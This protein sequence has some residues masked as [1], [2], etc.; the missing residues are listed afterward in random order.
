MKSRSIFHVDM[1]AFFAS[2]EI[3]RNPSLRGQPV[4][5]GGQADRRGVVSTCSYEARTFGVHSAMSMG[6]ALRRCPQAIVVPVDHAL[7]R[8][9]SQ[10][11]MTCLKAITTLVEPVSIDEAYLDVTAQVE[12]GSTP[13]ALGQQVREGV[14]EAT[15]L[16]C[17]VGAASNKL[18][19]KIASST[20]KPDQLFWIPTGLEAEFLA[21]Q[22]IEVIPGIGAKTA[23]RL[24]DARIHTVAD[25]QSIDMAELVERYGAQ[26]YRMALACQGIDHRDVVSERGPA[27]SLAAETTFEQDCAD[28]AILQS[29]LSALVQKACTRL[30]KHGLRTHTVCLKLR[31]SNFHTLTRSHMLDT[32]SNDMLLIERELQTLLSRTYDE[33]QAIRLI[34]MS[35]EKLTDGY[36][37]PLLWER[38]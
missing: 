37:Q 3:L 31:Y 13:L 19:A 18:V 21:P 5:V 26:G 33:Q 38:L 29:T 23:A 4:I 36:W 17:S 32:H 22:A 16:T 2:V 14:F 27:K 1:D 34:G 11:V 30:L 20:H 7:Y 15:G 35:L 24:H 10:K 25:L 8:S 28:I 12:A 9:Y 6:E